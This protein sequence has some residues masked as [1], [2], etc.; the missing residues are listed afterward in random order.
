MQIYACL[1]YPI[2][3]PEAVGWMK[4]S[5]TIAN[6]KGQNVA[7]MWFWDH[8]RLSHSEDNVRST[9]EF[10]RTNQGWTWV[11]YGVFNSHAAHVHPCG[12]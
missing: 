11:K 12:K 5:C 1:Q 4:R 3:I 9:V 6:V 7:V 10:E 2:L 8:T